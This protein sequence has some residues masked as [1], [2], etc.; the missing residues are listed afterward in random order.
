MQSSGMA[1]RTSNAEATADCEDRA[2]SLFARVEDY[3]EIFGG[4]SAT[5]SIPVIELPHGMGGFGEDVLVSQSSD[6]DYLEIFGTLD[7]GSFALSYEELVAGI[8]GKEGDSIQDEAHLSKLGKGVCELS[9]EVPNRGH[10]LFSEV[11]SMTLSSHLNGD[12]EQFNI[13]YGNNRLQNSVNNVGSPRTKSHAHGPDFEAEAVSSIGFDKNVSDE[14]ITSDC[15]LNSHIGWEQPGKQMGTLNQLF[16]GS[17]LNDFEDNFLD[18]QKPCKHLPSEDV[19]ANTKQHS[20]PSSYHS[21]SSGDLTSS[22]HGFLTLSD[23]RLSTQPMQVPPP[24]RPP[25]KIDMK[26]GLPKRIATGSPNRFCNKENLPEPSKTHQAEHVSGLCTCSALKETLKGIYP[27]FSNVEVDTNRAVTASAAAMLEAMEQ[28]QAKLNIAKELIKQKRENLQSDE[29]LGSGGHQICNGLLN[30]CAEGERANSNDDYKVVPN[31]VEKETSC[32]FAVEGIHCKESISFQLPNELIESL[33]EWKTDDKFYEF[34]STEKKLKPVQD[35]PSKE[36]QENFMTNRVS[37]G[38]TNHCIAAFKL[39]NEFDAYDEC[40]KHG[41]EILIW[42]IDRGNDIEDDSFDYH[43]INEKKPYIECDLFDQDDNSEHL[44]SEIVLTNAE[45]L[46]LLEKLPMPCLSREGAYKQAEVLH[47][48]KEEKHKFA[49]TASGMQ[50]WGIENEMRENQEYDI[51]ANKIKTNIEA[52]VDSCFGNGSRKEYHGQGHFQSDVCRDDEFVACARNTNIHYTT[53]EFGRNEKLVVPK[54]ASSLNTG[55]LS[56]DMESK[57]SSV[58]D[59]DKNMEGTGIEFQP[60]KLEKTE[61]LSCTLYSNELKD[62]EIECIDI[63]SKHENTTLFCTTVDYCESEKNEKLVHEV[64][65]MLD[66]ANRGKLKFA[67]V[68]IQQENFG[69][70]KVACE[71]Q[72]KR[73]NKMV[74]ELPRNVA[75]YVLEKSSDGREQTVEG[76][77]FIGKVQD[78]LELNKKVMESSGDQQVFHRVR[79][80]G[81]DA[82]RHAKPLDNI[83]WS[84]TDSCR[85]ALFN[86]A[87]KS[88]SDK[89]IDDDKTRKELLDIQKK[90]KIVQK[91]KSYKERER[92][93][94]KDR[95]A[96]EKET[97]EV[98]TGAK[99]TIAKTTEVCQGLCFKQSAEKLSAE[100]FEDSEKAASKSKLQE[101][102]SVVEWATAEALEHAVLLAHAEQ[103]SL[104][105]RGRAEVPAKALKVKNCAYSEARVVE[106]GVKE[107][108]LKSID[109]TSDRYD[110]QSDANSCRAGMARESPLRCKARQ[111]RQQRMVERAAKAL[112]EMNVRDLHAQRE[113]AVRNRLA[114]SLD[115]EVKR[116]STAKEGNLR[117]LLSTL[118]YILGH[119][120]GWQPIPLTEIITAAAVKKAYRKATLYVHPDKLQQRGA[121]IQHKYVCE[122]V[123]DLLKDAWNKFNQETPITMDSMHEC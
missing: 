72:Q 87:E 46:E 104:E 29:S 122:K 6:F 71:H 47:I 10:A 97:P 52:R 9:E 4:F 33:H 8:T 92:E 14:N 105:S 95:S 80:K 120:S 51:F 56:V 15:G 57:T 19:L 11:D 100:V 116:W 37:C 62:S 115:A 7:A 88:I 12:L 41:D 77:T 55:K 50:Q 68:P 117:A 85:L 70:V 113:L 103:A 53:P 13:L 74:Y 40:C 28:T 3:Y 111:E 63:V 26:L 73:E 106:P 23:I 17:M 78:A 93:H 66:V 30:D 32:V 121:S 83:D 34:M 102:C 123:F 118:Q 21:T 99:E 75:D 16:A 79:F 67:K 90:Q 76:N 39:E 82:V 36:Q 109:P 112:A 86:S 64:K 24:S 22:D 58:G 96:V 1:R 119:D 31:T 45:N 43:K 5:C 91:D 48:P 18:Y 25:P 42:N 110:T 61:K 2:S 49:Y 89:F 60:G 59:N 65:T 108:L 54:L 114:E 81:L 35:L 44:K 94:E 84:S 98:C 101:D 20:S 38:K 27:V 107:Y 69:K